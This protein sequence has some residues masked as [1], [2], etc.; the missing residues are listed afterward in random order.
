[1]SKHMIRRYTKD[2]RAAVDA[3]HAAHG[4][5]YWYADP[6]DPVNYET[7]V[8]EDDGRIIA[9]VTARYTAEAFLMLDK[10][11]GTPVDRLEVTQEIIEHSFN[12]AHELGLREV[13]IGVSMNERGWLKKLLRIPSMFLDNRFSVIMS[14]WHRFGGNKNG[15]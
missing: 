6:D 13:H 2:D 3:L 15:H 1:M 11:Y 9:S 4:D 8:I 12:R 10:S 7:W 5:K 14:I